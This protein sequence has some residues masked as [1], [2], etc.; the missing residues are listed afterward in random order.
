M[1]EENGQICGEV[2]GVNQVESMIKGTKVNLL[3]LLLVLFKKK[4]WVLLASPSMLV[5]FPQA[6][7]L[8]FN[9]LFFQKFEACKHYKISALHP[10][11]FCHKFFNP[12]LADL[13]DKN[14]TV[15]SLACFISCDL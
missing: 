14:M 2:K 8:H 6:C 10:A 5:R 9:K 1:Y 7:V 4:L 12:Y 3:S 13:S 11:S 15:L